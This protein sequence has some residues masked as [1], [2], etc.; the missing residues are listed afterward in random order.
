MR[1]ETAQLGQEMRRHLF[2]RVELRQAFRFA[3][4]EGVN[5][6]VR[7]EVAGQVG[8]AP[9]DAAAIPWTRN[10]GRRGTAPL[11]GQERP[12]GN[13]PGAGLD[14]GRELFHR[15]GLK[16][17]RH[18]QFAPQG[19]FDGGRKADGEQRMAA[20][21]EKAVGDPDPFHPEDGLP[22]LH[23]LFLQPVA[24]PHPAHPRGPGGIGSGQRPRV[25]L[26]V[27]GPREPLDPDEDGWDHRIRQGP[28]Q[29][30]AQA[31]RAGRLGCGDEI[32]D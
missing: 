11:H 10:N 17:R 20:E 8:V 27:G 12:R 15:G 24:G 22:G 21:V 18:G 26:A 4:P 3:G 30:C 23:Q 9:H 1:L 2:D 6:L 25:E 29:K 19:G 32:G 16:D 28:L 7:S 5:R 31:G 13:G 14:Q